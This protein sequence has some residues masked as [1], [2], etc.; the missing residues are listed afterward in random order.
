MKYKIKMELLLPGNNEPV[1][2]STEHLDEKS[3]SRLPANAH[4]WIGEMEE[5]SATFEDLGVTPHFHIGA[6]EMY[7]L[8]DSTPFASE[9]PETIDKDRTVWE[10]IRAAADLIEDPKFK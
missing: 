10:T 2:A 7:R 1:G 6:A 3:I 5:I 9:T 8:L 4:R